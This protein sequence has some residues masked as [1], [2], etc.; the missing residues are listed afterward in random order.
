[1]LTAL[2][3]CARERGW[4]LGLVYYV[5]LRFIQIVYSFLHLCS[6]S[7]SDHFSVCA[8][9]RM[10]ASVCVCVCVRLTCANV[11]CVCVYVCVCVC[12]QCVCVCARVCVC[13]CDS[14]E[15]AGS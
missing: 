13:V 9:V 15:D 7:E 2:N 4:G 3:V 12:T 1:M 14:D 8:H 11:H 6:L 10:C 5:S